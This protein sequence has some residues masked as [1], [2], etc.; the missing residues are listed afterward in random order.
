MD[1]DKFDVYA[2]IQRTTGSPREIEAEAL[3]LAAKK[4]M[5]CR[6]NWGTSERKQLLC[7]A[8]KFNQRLWS[9]FQAALGTKENPLPK[10]VKINLLRISAYIDRQIFLIMANP[11]PEKLAPIIGINLGIAAGM[12]KKPA[13]LS[14]GS[15]TEKVRSIGQIKERKRIF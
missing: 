6:D 12:R 10:K 9:F 11:S 14:T 3:T 5:D 15:I 8:L 4:L 13:P 7:A 1:N 2:K